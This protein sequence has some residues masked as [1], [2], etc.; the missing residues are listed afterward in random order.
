MA[1][2]F[3]EAYNLV[4]DRGTVSGTGSSDIATMHSGLGQ[5]R[6]NDIVGG[7]IGMG[8]TTGNLTR[9]RMLIQ[10]GQHHRIII[11]RL[12]YQSCEFDQ[13]RYA[14]VRLDGRAFRSL[15]APCAGRDS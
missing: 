4:F 1:V 3:G 7:N 13:V 11:T 6:T 8:N 5:I 14:S 9:L 10:K 12:R 2:L 15:G